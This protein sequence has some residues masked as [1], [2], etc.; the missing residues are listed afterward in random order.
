MISWVGEGWGYEHNSLLGCLRQSYA[1]F[2]D[3][4]QP[5]YLSVVVGCFNIC[6]ITFWQEVSKW[7]TAATS[8][9][10][11]ALLLFLSSIT[12]FFFHEQMTFSYLNNNE[13]FFTQCNPAKIKGI[14]NYIVVP[15]F[16]M[17][18]EMK[19]NWAGFNL[20]NAYNLFLR[21]THFLH[22]QNTAHVYIHL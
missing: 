12:W 1:A 13:R 11:N 22:F 10:N 15:K 18:I 16:K 7:I 5:H 6:W 21:K 3:I 2:L 14:I 4:Y 9:N 20:V 19:V 8:S 17:Y